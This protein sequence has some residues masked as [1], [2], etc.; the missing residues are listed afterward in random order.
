MD[1]DELQEL[2]GRSRGRAMVTG[3]AGLLRRS[4]RMSGQLLIGVIF[5]CCFISVQ[6]VLLLLV[7]APGIATFARHSNCSTSRT[8]DNANTSVYFVKHQDKIWTSEELCSIE[9]AAH[10]YPQYNIVIVNLLR[11]NSPIAVSPEDNV[12]I[13]RR[14]AKKLSNVRSVDT[15]ARKFFAKSVMSKRIQAD[16]LRS[17]EIESAAKFQLIWDSPGVSLEPLLV[18]QLESI[19]P[20]FADKDEVDLDASVQIDAD[21]Q[22]TS[23]PCQS[24]IGFVLDRMA[25][26]ATSFAD[27]RALMESTL[28]QYCNRITGCNGVRIVKSI[29]KKLFNVSCPIVDSLSV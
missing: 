23:V 12:D 19:Q 1:K 24:F 17:E 28:S 15:S 10:L 3:A 14:L 21:F 20:Y 25:K 5:V 26:P 9:T 7:F 2:C 4:T 29:S 13:T 22:A 11:D 6:L 18:H 27:R 8:F 16:D